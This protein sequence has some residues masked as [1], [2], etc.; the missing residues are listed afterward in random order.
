M[1]TLLRLFAFAAIFFANTVVFAQTSTKGF[2]FQ[3]YAIDPDGKTLSSV[4]I[5]VKF[6][7][8]SISNAGSPFVDKQTTS[9]MHLG[10]FI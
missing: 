7:L 9:P 8:S 6:T 3:G 2:S 5:T 1:I 10:C 4:N